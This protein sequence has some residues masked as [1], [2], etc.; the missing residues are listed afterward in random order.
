MEERPSELGL[1]LLLLRHLRLVLRAAGAGSDRLL[2]E[3]DRRSVRASH[4]PCRL[5]GR[6]GRVLLLQVQ[7]LGG[8]QRLRLRL[9]LLY[10]RNGLK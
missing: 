10:N 9:L 6:V 1:G 4:I 5:V 2:L 7:L 8:V 3:G